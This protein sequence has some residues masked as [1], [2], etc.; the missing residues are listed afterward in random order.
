MTMKPLWYRPVG[1]VTTSDEP[2][3]PITDNRLNRT[4][5]LKQIALTDIDLQSGDAQDVVDVT[6]VGLYVSTVFLFYDHNFMSEGPP[7]LWE[8]L[9]CIHDIWLNDLQHRYT[10]RRAAIQGHIDIVRFLLD[11]VKYM[12]PD[13]DAV[14]YLQAARFDYDWREHASEDGAE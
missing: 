7:L 5:T 10:S 8:T 14:A 2:P 13:T 9:P 1:D 3:I 6:K 12:Q 11:M 4:D